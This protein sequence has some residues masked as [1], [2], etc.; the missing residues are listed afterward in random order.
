MCRGACVACVGE[1]CEGAWEAVSASEG[2]EVKF[3]PRL[4]L[5]GSTNHARTIQTGRP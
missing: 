5:M 4:S 2:D 1:P 3:S